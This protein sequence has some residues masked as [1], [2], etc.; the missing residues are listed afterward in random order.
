MAL[1]KCHIGFGIRTQFQFTFCKPSMLL[2][3]K[4]QLQPKIVL[5]HKALLLT[6]HPRSHTTQSNHQDNMP[7]TNC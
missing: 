4:P 6:K 7:F 2:E 3:A 5:K 1:F